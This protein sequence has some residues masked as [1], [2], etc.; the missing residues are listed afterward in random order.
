MDSKTAKLRAEKLKREINDLRYRYHVLDDP[1]VTDEVYDSL[2]VELKQLEAR[3]PELLSPDSPTQRIGGKPLDKFKKVAHET[4][5]LSLNDAF[6]EEEMMDWEKRLKRLEP[7]GK[8]N[9]V[10]ELKFDGLATSLVYEK[11]LFVQGSTRGDGLVGEDITQNLKTIHAIPLRLDFELKS[12]GLSH[13]SRASEE[14][15]TRVT[16]N[17]KKTKKIEVR[18]EVIMRKRDFIKLNK[19]E[20]G[21]YANPRNTAAGAVRQLDPAIT[22]SRKL[23]WHGYHLVTDLGQKTHGEEHQILD[24]LGFPADDTAIYKD[25]NGVFEFWENVVKTRER[26]DFEVDGIVVQIDELDM[27]RRFGVVGKAPRGS[28]A[29]KFAAKKATTIVEEIKVQVGRQGNLTPIA[30]MRPVKVGGVTITHASLH[31]EDEIRRIGLKIGDTVVVQRAGDV[32]PQIVEILPKLRSGKEKDFHMPKRCPVCGAEVKRQQISAGREKGASL[33]C[34]NRNCLAKNL[35]RI[36]HFVNAFEIYTVGP[37]IVERFKDEGLISDAADLFALKKEDIAGLP[38]FGEKSAENIIASI[39]GHKK[40]S[41]PRFLMA[42]GILHVGEQT[43][44]DLARVFGTLH[45]L[46]HASLEQLNAIENI[47]DVVAQSVYE[48]FRDPQNQKSIDRL[49]E[50]GVRIKNQE[51]RI[52]EGKLAGLKIL[53]TGTLETMSREEAKR[54][55]MENGGDWVSAVSKNTDYLVAGENPGSKLGRAE[56]LGVNILNEVDFLKLI[57]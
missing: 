28:I 49:L 57:G 2:T 44:F 13:D 8:W 22:A 42:L 47:G 5:M 12:S 14:L 27:F 17:L 7:Y 29:Y 52:K 19:K 11:G 53:V 30:V 46:R 4:R 55:V 33:V 26:R 45:K 36:E 23:F 16:E 6:S 51:S 38:R 50:R 20:H 37:K 15:K 41:L 34:T 48:F 3:F 43:A 24:V 9:Y 21:K 25:L 54:L 35:R 1:Q 39:E 40:V 10:C 32:I 31:N 18:G 56:K